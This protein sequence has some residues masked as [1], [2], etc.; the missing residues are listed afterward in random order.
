MGP[1]RRKRGGGDIANAVIPRKKRRKL[2]RTAKKQRRVSYQSK[3]EQSGSQGNV[4][5]AAGR[6]ETPNASEAA[7]TSGVRKSKTLKES[8]TGLPQGR[9]KEPS[10]VK[11]EESSRP[12][13]KESS[14]PQ[15]SCPKGNK[16]STR[17]SG[18]SEGRPS[19]QQADQKDKED[20][21]KLERLLK[22]DKKK[23]G[24]PNSFRQ[25]GLDCI[26]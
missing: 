13:E 22:I 4:D 23:R 6:K 7:L 18:R 8:S 10:G 3:F 14:R 21:E 24:V 5:I 26:L 16:P 12:Q 9:R 19:L 2:E 11:G 25:D 17:T 1:P 15:S 20:I